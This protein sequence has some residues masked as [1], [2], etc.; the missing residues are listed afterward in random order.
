[1]CY[2]IF[3]RRRIRTRAEDK[4]CAKLSLGL[5][6]FFG[7]TDFRPGQE[8][9]VRAVLEGKNVLAVMPTGAGKSLCYQLPALLQG[10]LTLVVSP[11]I[12]LMHDQLEKLKERGIL[13]DRLDS[14][15]SERQVAKVMHSLGV[16]D[17]ARPTILYL[18]PERVA[19]R[20]FRAALVKR[21]PDG[22]RL[23]VVDEAHCISQWGHDFRPAYLG[24]GDAARE[25]GSKSLLAL[26]ATA[27]PKVRQDILDRLSIPDATLV[28]VG[29]VRPNLSFA[30]VRARSEDDKRK[31]LAELLS[32]LTT[33]GQG[34]VY[35]ATVK[36][37]E[38]LGAFLTDAGLAVGVYH[39][40]LTS[41]VRT[42]V[43]N[44]FMQGSSG[45]RVMIATNAFGL[46]VDKPDLRYVVHYHFP[47]SLEAY[48]QEAG[49]AGR[50]GQPAHCVL[51][52][53]PQ[54]RRIQA[55]FLG[56]RY[57]DGKDVRRLLEVLTRAAKDGEAPSTEELSERADLG[58]RKTIV[59]LQQLRDAELVTERD[60][61]FRPTL[62]SYGA[63]ELADVVQR[64]VARRVDDRRRLEAIERYCE[65][66]M[67]RV[68][69]LSIYFGEETPP[70]CGRC[71]SCLRQARLARAAS[72][73]LSTRKGTQQAAA[74]R[75]RPLV[76]H[77]EFG[78]G[79]VIAERGDLITVFFPAVG[80]KTLRAKF[81][82]VV[83]RAAS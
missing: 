19:D 63:E 70:P 50:D 69:I 1:V 78:E 80:E 74:A 68:R 40:R 46:G 21:R 45:P 72:A 77:P 24:L 8:D 29:T 26:T 47:G 32:R 11:L 15:M 61:A 42:Q 58:L 7:L 57:P 39:G 34:I 44:T 48:Y 81:V 4:D 76:A 83:G 56:G 10:G 35:V 3:V 59:L 66:T 54:D 62:E 12:S 22:V 6:R 71:D 43:Q 14:T 36:A 27:P 30:V 13:A 31:K 23:F 55:F 73:P 64:Y 17:P 65:S 75:V 9:V 2:P 41:P 49:R 38:E 5:R 82:R 51:L 33:Q 79:E 28:A 53:C 52:Y 25:L 60:G 18:T 20:A 67:C 37:A 16:G